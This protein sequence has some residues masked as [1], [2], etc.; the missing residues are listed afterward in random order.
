MTPLAYTFL[1]RPER[2]IGY[3][4][5]GLDS[6]T[7]WD[8]GKQLRGHVTEFIQRFYNTMNDG[9]AVELGKGNVPLPTTH[10]RIR[11]ALY[12]FVHHSMSRLRVSLPTGPPSSASPK[13]DPVEEEGDGTR[14]EVAL[15][16]ARTASFAARD[17]LS[18]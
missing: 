7:V 13:L 6:P 5:K 16:D 9:S 3:S 18:L 4:W 12:S 8:V 11:L 17:K 15:L 1:I 2:V 14:E 10:S